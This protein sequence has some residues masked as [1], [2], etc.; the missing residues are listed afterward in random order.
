MVDYALIL[1]GGSS[2]RMKQDKASLVRPDGM[3]QLEFTA[4]LLSDLAVKTVLISS[5]K[6]AQL[7]RTEWLPDR[8]PDMGP[9]AGIDSAYCHINSRQEDRTDDVSLLVLPCDMP[10]LSRSTLQPLLEA[11][12]QGHGV[13]YERAFFPCVLRLNS[14]LADYLADRLQTPDADRSLKGLLRHMKTEL[15][16]APNPKHL[17]STNTPEDWSLFQQSFTHEENLNG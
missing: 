15:I 13:A 1:A 4:S 16:P 7:A 11:S 17:I 5:Q 3:T 12:F 10:Y 14:Q 8:Y 6:D 9:L 2:S